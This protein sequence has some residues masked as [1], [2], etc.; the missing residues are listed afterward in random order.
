MLNRSIEGG[1][2]RTNLWSGTF[3]ALM[4]PLR[5]FLN[6][7]VYGLRGRKPPL[8]CLLLARKFPCVGRLF[9]FED[10]LEEEADAY[11]IDLTRLKAEYKEAAIFTTTF[12]LGE[13]GLEDIGDLDAWIPR[14]YDLYVVGLQECLCMEELQA[15]IHEHLGGPKRFTLF[16]QAIG[17]TQTKLGFHGMIVLAVYAR[18]EDV[19]S[20]SFVPYESANAKVNQGVSLGVA[21]AGNKGAVGLGFRYH[22]ASVGVITCHFASDS[23]G[24]AKLP[25]RNCDAVSTLREAVLVAENGGFD[26]HLMHHHT[27]R[28]GRME[29]MESMG[30]PMW[31]WE[32]A[33]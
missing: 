19:K 11:G 14:A 15:G 25:S 28:I 31:G 23:K 8:L 13:C 24:K 5:G 18:T 9:F 27:V 30:Q 6:S 4:M 7:L 16:T 26:A 21:K 1:T 17:S 33:A 29:R 3:H 22:D 10:D 12:N 20:G 2:G 32:R